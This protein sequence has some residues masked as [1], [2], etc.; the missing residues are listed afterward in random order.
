[1]ALASNRNL[2]EQN[3]D[4]KPRLE[5]QREHLVE[6]YSELEGVRDTYR[7]HCD[8]KGEGWRES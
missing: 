1:M 8:Q 4:M 3:L 5:R 6:R 7:Q 2:A